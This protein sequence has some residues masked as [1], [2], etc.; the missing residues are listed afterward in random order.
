MRMKPLI[1]ITPS[2]SLDQAGHGTFYRYCLSRTYIDSVRQAGGVPLILPTDKRTSPR[3]C[4]GSTASFS[5][6]VAILI[7]L[8]METTKSTRRPMASTMSATRSKSRR[9]PGRPNTTYLP[10]AFVAGFR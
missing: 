2:P 9:S 7:R 10:Y 1:G 4:L 8:D 3:F 6:E 5:V